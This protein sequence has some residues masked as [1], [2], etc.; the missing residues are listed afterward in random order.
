MVG[1]SQGVKA[2]EEN[3]TTKTSEEMGKRQAAEKRV[4][5]EAVGNPWV[6]EIRQEKF[7]ARLTG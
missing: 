2:L 5:P 6:E 3:E 7:G 1:L 4:M